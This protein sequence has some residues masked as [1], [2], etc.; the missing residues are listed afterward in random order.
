MDGQN[1]A[2]QPPQAPEPAH[3]QLPPSDQDVRSL[4]VAQ[5][6]IMVASLAG[7]ISLFF[8]GFWLSAAGLVCGIIGFRKFKALI[9]SQSS[10]SSVATRFKKSSIVSIVICSIVTVL[11]VVSAVILYPIVLQALETGDYANFM[12]GT[13][14]GTPSG[15]NSTWG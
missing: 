13:G 4:K 12:P 2:P 15:G 1:N 5:N 7:P 6:L 11:N 10:I 8:G 3:S 9:Q 14:T